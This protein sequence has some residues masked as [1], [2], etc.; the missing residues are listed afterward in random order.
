MGDGSHASEADAERAARLVS[1]L[2]KVFGYSLTGYVSEK[3]IFCLFGCGN[4]GKTT[5]LESVR[6]VLWEYAAQI[7][8]DTLMSHRQRE[9]NASL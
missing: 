9:S 6:F 7:Q 4:N 5:L 3:V 1:Y 2:Q 8:I